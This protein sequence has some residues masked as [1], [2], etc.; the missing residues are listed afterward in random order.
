M[1]QLLARTPP[2]AN[3][4][5]GPRHDQNRGT[6]TPVVAGIDDPFAGRQT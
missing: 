4:V 6:A 1:I 5:S 2:C 3:R